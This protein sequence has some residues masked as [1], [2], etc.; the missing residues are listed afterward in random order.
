MDDKIIEAKF[1]KNILAW[2]LLVI[3][4]VLLVVSL[5]FA[6]NEYNTRTYY[7]SYY[8]FGVY[9][10]KT[11]TAAERYGSFGNYITSELI[12]FICFEGGLD[13]WSAPVFY[14][15]VIV[16]LLAG[17]FF[18]KMSRGKLLITSKK[19]TGKASFGKQIDLSLSQISSVA[20]G[21]C[22]QLSIGTSSGNIHFWFIKNR[23]EVYTALSDL[24]AKVQ[25]ENADQI[26][27]DPLSSTANELKKYKELLDSGVI[28]QEEFNAK[29]KQLLGL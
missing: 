9:E 10:S 20:L 19:V 8:I 16:L 2:T 14:L 4:I 15:S 29:K 21:T 3:G 12:E 11:K 18:W 26:P 25:V 13:Y 22:R 7:D 6:V 27:V 23:N 5:L 28:T 24:I 1:Q 17:F